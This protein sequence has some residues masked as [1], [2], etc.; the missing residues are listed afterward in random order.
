MLLGVHV[1]LFA[2]GLQ[3]DV[4][5]RERMGSKGRQAGDGEICKLSRIPVKIAR[6]SESDAKEIRRENF[7]ICIKHSI[8]LGPEDTAVEDSSANN[9]K[10]TIDDP[11][12][13]R[14]PNIVPHWPEQNEEGRQA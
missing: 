2:A 6:T 1:S 5:N 11:Q 14:R 4:R 8:I 12:K 3:I 9:T 7:N 10:E 13:N